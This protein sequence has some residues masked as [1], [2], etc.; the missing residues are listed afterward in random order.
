MKKRTASFP[1]E[2]VLFSLFYSRKVSLYLF[3]QRFDLIL[4]ERGER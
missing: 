1:N 2:A 4:A 3:V